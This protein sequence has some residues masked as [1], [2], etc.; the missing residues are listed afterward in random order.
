MATK[1][2]TYTIT[3]GEVAENGI[4]ME[5]LGEKAEEGFSVSELLA[6]RT[7]F[8]EA[9]Y[10]AYYI[11][12]NKHC[13][14]ELNPPK[15]GVLLVKNGATIGGNNINELLA[16]QDEL[17]YDTT[18][19]MRGKLV[20]SIARYNLCFA[21]YD[22]EPDIENGKGTVVNFDDLPALSSLRQAL[23]DYLG[24]KARDLYGEGNKYYDIKKCGIGYHG[25]TERRIVI[26]VRLGE[27][28]D[29]AYLWY[30]A[31]KPVGER[32]MITLDPGDMYVMSDKAVGYDWKKKL[33]PTL[34]HS[35]G[36]D[37]YTKIPVK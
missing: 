19:I 14:E 31:Y 18:K 2:T 4:N 5:Q 36:C 10:E 20:N 33:I 26:G 9:G 25:D 35:A 21:D 15:A 24:E 1:N 17:E 32:V 27:P 8:R 28:M 12:L 6:A 22:Q 34:R 23:P 3:F 16:E 29:L 13:P 37:K 11:N 7:K 30:Y